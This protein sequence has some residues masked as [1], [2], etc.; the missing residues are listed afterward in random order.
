MM[1]AEIRRPVF[2]GVHMVRGLWFDVEL[3]GESAA[4]RRIF[5]HWEPGSRLYRA[6]GGYVLELPGA[7][8]RRCADLDGAPLCDVDGVLSSAPLTKGER[9]A[10]ASGAVCLVRGAQPEVVHLSAAMRIDPSIWLDLRNIPLREPLQA[11]AGRHKV[12]IADAEQTKSLRAILG[13]AIP[14]P[15]RQRSEF[16]RNAAASLRDGKP[17]HGARPDAQ[18]GTG[19]AA[20]LGKVSLG[21]LGLLLSWAGAGGRS[22]QSGAPATGVA[23]P[24]SLSPW[25]QRLSDFAARLA[26]FTRV[27]KLLGRQQ[28]A[29]LK[30]MMDLF[31]DGNWEE[32]LKHAIPLDSLNTEPARPAFGTPSPRADLTIRAPN[33][34]AA[35]IGLGNELEQHLRQTYRRTFERLDRD[36]RIDE[37]VFVLAELLK[38]GAEAVTYLERKGRLEQAAELAETLELPPEIA[39]RLWW[40]AGDSERA[41]QLARH[42][43]TFA[44]ALRVLEKSHAKEAPGLRKLWAE[45]LAAQGSLAEAAEAIWPLEECRAMARDWLLMAEQSGGTLGARALVQK[46]LLAPETLADSETAI[47]SIL[48][49]GGEDGAQMRARLALALLA[50]KSQS[51]ATKRLAAELLRAIVPERV[52]GLNQLEKNDISKL[53]AFAD[54]SMLRADL[55]ALNF[56]GMPKADALAARHSPLVLRL[57]ERGLQSIHDV[58]VL[59]DGQYL[60]ALGESGV[61][62]ID[63]RARPLAH[64]PIPAHRLVLADS[65]QRALALARR[66]QSYRISRLDLLTSHVQDWVS[67]PLRFWS[68]AYDGVTWTVVVENRLLALDTT[69]DHVLATWQVAELPG[70]IVDFAEDGVYQVMLMDVPEGIEQWRYMLPARRLFQRDGLPKP[71]SDVWRVVPCAAHTA[72]VKIT[73]LSEGDEVTLIVRKQAVPGEF[74]LRLGALTNPPEIQIHRGWISALM[75][76][77][78]VARCLVADLKDGSIKADL[79]LLQS[80]APRVS[81]HDRHVVL[82]DRAGRLIDIDCDTGQSRTLIVN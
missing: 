77:R 65:G 28:A 7:R 31:E 30:R 5:A 9:A 1:Q 24:S 20:G 68:H 81:L 80:E 47:E 62:R 56:P 76:D 29:Y 74:R 55:P 21:M 39:V 37:A 40:L 16:L 66:D 35:S 64:Y 38:S 11:P 67:L 26:L 8:L 57:E 25:A 60:L 22:S 52:A 10:V 61:L 82:V 75:T 32:A 73:L 41:A 69:R 18:Q 72:P 19:L 27:S 54:A 3:I 79:T 42:S 48:A 43:N 14:E 46:L 12:E 58:R 53:L 2:D 23:R 44:E 34:L 78:F 71:D 45:H 50:L 70:P 51:T 6:S 59:P 4:R 36:G 33:R 63:R 17:S 49:A 15:S 13:D